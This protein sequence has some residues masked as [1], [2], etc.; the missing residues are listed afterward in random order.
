MATNLISKP[1]SERIDTERGLLDK[2]ES[3]DTSIDQTTFPIAPAETCNE[4]REQH[5]KGQDEKPIV[6]VL[7]HNNGIVVQVRDVGAAPV[8]GV[9]LEH[10]PHEVRVPHS[11]PHTVWVFGCVGPSVVCSMLAAPPANRALNGTASN[12]S[13]EDSEWQAPKD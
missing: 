6:L 4:H 10:H 3:Q 1:M 12:A 2:E 11:L 13:K 5:S 8:L 9:L 7:P